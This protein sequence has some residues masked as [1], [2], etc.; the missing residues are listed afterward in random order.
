M[1]ST[2]ALGGIFLLTALIAGCKIEVTAPEGA[3]VRTESGAY[4]CIGPNVCTIEVND[5]FFDETFTIETERG[6]ASAGWKRR[7]RGLCGG[8]DTPCRLFTS[9]FEGND[10]LMAILESDETFF[11]EALVAPSSLDVQV[12]VL[13]EHGDIG[14]VDLASGSYERI[15]EYDRQ[16]EFDLDNRGCTRQGQIVRYQGTIYV[17]MER[18]LWKKGPGDADF[19]LVGS[20][21]FEELDDFFVY[22]ERFFYVTTDGLVF[23]GEIGRA[24][25]DTAVGE[26]TG[27]RREGDFSD[28]EGLSHAVYSKGTNSLFAYI[29]CTSCSTPPNIARLDPATLEQIG[30]TSS[31][32]FLPDA[33]FAIGDFLYSIDQAVVER[34]NVLTGEVEGRL[35]GLERLPLEVCDVSY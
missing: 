33:P 6:I 34:L 5:L 24:F 31:S 2:L 12:I 16:S 15:Y 10:A 26:I 13:D 19:V 18:E 35:V 32:G 22:N 20:T 30:L 4:V 28:F 11:L 23:S 27:I 1:K 17:A 25:A 3:T 21:G 8:K 9:G 7:A 29:R 14:L